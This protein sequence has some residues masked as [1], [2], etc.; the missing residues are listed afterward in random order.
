MRKY[1]LTLYAFVTYFFLFYS[2]KLYSSSGFFQTKTS[3]VLEKPPH[4]QTCTA[5]AVSLRVSRIWSQRAPRGTARR[6]TSRCA[7]L[8]G[9][10]V[11]RL[12]QLVLFKYFRLI[13]RLRSCELSTFYKRNCKQN[14][15]FLMKSLLPPFFSFLS[16]LGVPLLLHTHQSQRLRWSRGACQRTPA[17]CWAVPRPSPGC[18]CHL[19]HSWPHQVQVLLYQTKSRCFKTLPA[20]SL[21]C[22][23]GMAGS[24]VSLL[25]EGVGCS[26]GNRVV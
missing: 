12:K 1:V 3:S 19:L 20:A 5:P 18:T 26:G 17:W 11:T 25:P 21:S 14:T 23:A 6:D 8:H 7:G 22:G 2:S 16:Y 13:S 24:E 4:K 9:V 15:S 10:S